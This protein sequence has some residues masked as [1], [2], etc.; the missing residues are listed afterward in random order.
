M[1]ELRGA[2]AATTLGTT[3]EKR[4]VHVYSRRCPMT[5]LRCYNYSKEE[6]VRENKRNLAEIPLKVVV[7]SE[8]HVYLRTE[9]RFSIDENKGNK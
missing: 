9:T 6:V 5:S 8:I 2:E 3:V 4:E 1:G 7:L